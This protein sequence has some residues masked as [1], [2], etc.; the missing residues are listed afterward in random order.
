MAAMESI[1]SLNGVMRFL[2][3]AAVVSGL[4]FFLAFGRIPTGL[5]GTVVRHNLN[6]GIDA[7]PLVYGDVEN[8]QEL[9]AGVV[10]LRKQAAASKG[11]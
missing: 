8:M 3:A 6:E 4:F 9:E 11:Q 10:T 5:V 1:R 7:T 2:V